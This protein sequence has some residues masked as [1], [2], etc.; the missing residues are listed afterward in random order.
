MS[1][2]PDL[3][4]G[5]RFDFTKPLN[6]SFAL[7]HSF[8]LG[9]VDIPSHAGQPAL[10]TSLGHYE[11]GANLVSPT[12]DMIIGRVLTDGRVT[13]RVKKDITPNVG[14]KLQA[15]LSPER[16]ASQAMVDVDLRGAD[17]N[18][19]IKIGNQ[20]FYGEKR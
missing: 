3:F 18:G 16:G 1:L 17:W 9:S 6:N 4:E 19:Q 12:G 2:K 20:Q 15:Q 10:K 13:G 5:F 14:V 11:F 8:F 7:T